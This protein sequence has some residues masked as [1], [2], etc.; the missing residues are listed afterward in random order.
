VTSWPRKARGPII[1]VD[2]S[3]EIDLH[4][5]DERYGERS[6]LSSSVS[7]CAARR[8]HFDSNACRTVGSNLQRKS[9]RALADFLYEP[10]LEGIGMRDWNCSSVRLA[11]G[12]AYTMLQIEKQGVPLSESWAAGPAVGGDEAARRSLILSPPLVRSYE[13]PWTF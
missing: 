11:Q 9:V 7:A 1:A 6:I 13:R 12:Y 2:V 8:R 10:P 3:G 5:D 4:A